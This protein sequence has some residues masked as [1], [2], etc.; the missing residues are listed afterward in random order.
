MFHPLTWRWWGLWLYCS[1]PPG[2][3][4]AFWLTVTS[5][6]LI[7]SLYVLNMLRQHPQHHMQPSPW[8]VSSLI[9]DQKLLKALFVVFCCVYRAASF[10]FSLNKVSWSPSGR[11]LNLLF[12]SSWFV[13]ERVPQ[14]WADME[15][16]WFL[17]TSKQ[18][19]F[20][21]LQ[22]LSSVTSKC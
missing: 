20:F 6:M 13:S 19:R 17:S 3:H 22:K 4:W 12:S 16:S 2:G 1:Q 10:L 14:G 11:E 15:A 18:T 5:S 9:S 21:Y 7:Y 8:R